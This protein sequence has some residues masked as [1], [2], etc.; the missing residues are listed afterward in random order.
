ML[1]IIYWAWWSLTDKIGTALGFSNANKDG[2]HFDYIV[3][4]YD[5]NCSDHEP[6]EDWSY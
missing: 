2:E 6:E 5:P 4:P 3:N 1:A